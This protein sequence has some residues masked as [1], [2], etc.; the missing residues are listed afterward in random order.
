MCA[1]E[2]RE[3]LL[4]ARLPGSCLSNKLTEWPADL[5]DSIDSSIRLKRTKQNKWPSGCSFVGPVK[6]ADWLNGRQI[7]LCFTNKQA[8]W[9]KNRVG[10][11]VWLIYRENDGL[12]GWLT[13]RDTEWLCSSS[14]HTDWRSLHENLLNGFSAVCQRTTNKRAR[15]VNTP[16]KHCLCRREQ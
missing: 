10:C 2:W 9:L 8:D 16:T 11:S 5:F 4:I 1:I 3:Q 13:D 14:K 12:A 7:W 6:N 15:N